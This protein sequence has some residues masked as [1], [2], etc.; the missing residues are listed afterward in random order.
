M[1]GR[2]HAGEFR[3]RDVGRH[4][5]LRD[6]LRSLPVSVRPTI[7][8]LVV[9]RPSRALIAAVLSWHLSARAETRADHIVVSPAGLATSFTYVAADLA[10][11]LQGCLRRERAVHRNATEYALVQGFAVQA[12]QVCRRLFAM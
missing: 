1:L 11:H 10:A 5:P 2:Q 6:R 7:S 4:D 9:R 3:R 12:S 8:R